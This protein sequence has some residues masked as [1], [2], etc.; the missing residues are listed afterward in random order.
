MKRGFTL[1][2]VLITLGIIGVVA[3]MTMP[4]LIGS[5]KK[6]AAVSQLKKVYSS[7]LQSVEFSKLENGDILDWDWNLDAYSFFM[8]YLGSNFQIVQNCGNKSGCWNTRGGYMLKGGVYGD[9]PLKSYWY[10]ILLS[11]GTFIALQKQD[12]KHVHITVDVNGEKAPNT[13]GKDIFV[14]TM[15]SQAVKD[16]YHNISAPGLYMYGHGLTTEAIKSHSLGCSK[17]SAGLMCGEKILMDGWEMNK[18]YPWK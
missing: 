12:N 3:S 15:T 7:L 6:K 1:A 17:N 4:V 10:K 13:Y 16:A 5:Y 14:M 8:K 2:E 18:D 11:D 9:N